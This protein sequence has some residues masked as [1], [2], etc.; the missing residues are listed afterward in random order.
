MTYGERERIYKKAIDTYG[1]F[2]QAVIAMEEMSELVKELSKNYRGK[3]NK[4]AIAEEV[5][6]VSIM[7]EQLSMIYNIKEEIEVWKRRKLDRLDKGLSNGIHK[8]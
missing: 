6:D 8:T 7:L 4:E 3:Q 1:P 5:A 2:N